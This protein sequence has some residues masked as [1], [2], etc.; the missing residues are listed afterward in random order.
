MKAGGLVGCLIAA[1]CVTA[2]SGCAAKRSH[3]TEAGPATAMQT[4]HLQK[5]SPRLLRICI[6]VL[7]VATCPKLVPD[8]LVR[9]TGVPG[10][11][12]RIPYVSSVSQDSDAS[13]V[14]I[15]IGEDQSASGTGSPP[16]FVHIVFEVVRS[17][18][19]LRGV[20]ICHA[21]PGASTTA[22]MTDS[23]QTVPKYLGG[24]TW[25]GR[26]GILSLVP[27]FSQLDSIH[28]GHLVFC[29]HD[30]NVVRLVS[31]HAWAPLSET[32]ATLRALVAS[33]P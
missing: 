23:R 17:P 32:R 24:I 13:F 20:I 18:S 21:E 14:S 30:K 22:P 1:V 31:L 27:P 15:G 12:I 10:P 11:G 25:G 4:I 7:G 8:T 26:H 33:I 9:A 5:M 6:R 3:G 16:G 28:S 29:W 2:T 19:I